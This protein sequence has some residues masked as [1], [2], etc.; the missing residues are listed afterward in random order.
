MG[1][2]N[3]CLY[4]DYFFNDRV[5]ALMHLLQQLDCPDENHSHIRQDR[6]V[7]HTIKMIKLYGSEYPD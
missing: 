7:E 1:G 6:V 3:V 2:F 4:C 5:D